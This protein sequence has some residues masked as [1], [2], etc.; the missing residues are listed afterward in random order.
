MARIL[1]IDAEKT[2][3]WMFRE[4]LEPQGHQVAEAPDG[5]TGL[6]RYRAQPADLVIVDLRRPDRAGVDTVMELRRLN[7]GCKI[8]ATSAGS[9]DG[10]PDPLPA[11]QDAGAQRTFR[12]P[13]SLDEMETAIRELLGSVHA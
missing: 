11:A 1:V 8:I 10:A 7:P 12:K 3:R 9:R 5:T 2:I 6:E 13:F 4:M